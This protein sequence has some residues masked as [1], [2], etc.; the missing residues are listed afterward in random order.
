[1]KSNRVSLDFFD[2]FDTRLMAGRGFITGFHATED[3]PLLKFL[4]KSSVGLTFDTTRGDNAGTFT[5]DTAPR[6]SGT[7]NPPADSFGLKN[8]SRCSLS[9]MRA[10]TVANQRSWTLNCWLVV[11]LS[12]HC[13][14]ARRTDG[15]MNS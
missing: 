6:C 13:T 1:M 4:R 5:D 15:S 2:A 10:P 11:L 9:S 8:R 3:D 7:M 14:I 12:G